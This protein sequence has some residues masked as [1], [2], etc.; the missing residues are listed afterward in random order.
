MHFDERFSEKLKSSISIGLMKG[1]HLSR[2][3]A[4]NTFFEWSLQ[5]ILCFD[6]I[7][8]VHLGGNRVFWSFWGVSPRNDPL[9]KSHEIEN[10]FFFHCIQPSLSAGQWKQDCPDPY[11]VFL[12][13][14]IIV[15][16][17]WKKDLR[18]RRC[19]NS[20]FRTSPRL[21]LK[22]KETSLN[23]VSNICFRKNP[24]N[25]VLCAVLF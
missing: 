10:W 16:I 5:Q 24:L 22:L 15:D 12:F 11:K 9:Q 2:G 6:S 25:L 8:N 19:M 1:L 20:Y 23:W 13:F 17:F 18:R 21:S 4:N 3:N 7:L 14:K